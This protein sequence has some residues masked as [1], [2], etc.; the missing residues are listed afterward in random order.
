MML[1][2]VIVLW[3]GKVLGG[4]TTVIIPTSMVCTWEQERIVTPEYNGTTGIIIL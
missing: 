2:V 1:I 4:T 3:T